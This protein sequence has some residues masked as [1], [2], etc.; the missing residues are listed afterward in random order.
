MA[1]L[2]VAQVSCVDK[3][4]E[5]EFKISI[6][7]DVIMG[8][9]IIDV[10]NAN[11]DETQISGTIVFEGEGSDLIYTSSGNKSFE[12]SEGLLDVGILSSANISKENPI[13]VLATITADGY[14]SKTIPVVFNGNE[15]INQIN[16]N[17][18]E[19]DNLPEGIQIAD[20][21]SVLVDNKITESVIFNPVNSS[22][23]TLGKFEIPEG[24]SF[25]DENGN[26][27]EGD[28]IIV[29]VA[30]FENNYFDDA[31]NIFGNNTFLPSVANVN[32]K[33]NKK[34]SKVFGKTS[35][36]DTEVTVKFGLSLNFSFYIWVRQGAKVTYVYELSKPVILYSNLGSS[37]RDF[38]RNGELFQEGDKINCYK[39]P[40]YIRNSLYNI[41]SAIIASTK[42]SEGVV[43]KIGYSKYGNVEVSHSGSYFFGY[44]KAS[45]CNIDDETNIKFVNSGVP[46]YY[47]YIIYDNYIKNANRKILTYGSFYMSSE[48][49]N[50]FLFKN[51]FTYFK[52]NDVLLE[53]YALDPKKSP[54][55]YSN[56]GI[57]VYSSEFL[58]CEVGDVIDISNN[59]CLEEEYDIDLKIDCPK[60]NLVL[61]S[62]PVY[63][64]SNK[65]NNKTYQYFA[66]VM[67][68]KINGKGPCLED[69]EE[70]QFKF[71]Y[72]G[73][74]R[75][76]PIITG[77][78]F[79]EQG[80]DFDEDELCEFIEGALKK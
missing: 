66:R 42:Y 57:N 80:F 63:F 40:E 21:S 59:F 41:N 76:S 50:D 79:K 24:T 70:Y 26:I 23:E 8:N 27:I 19:K 72:D 47:K 18:L 68:G 9:T 10:V 30:V 32:L 56:N 36:T 71:L 20:L 15:G 38:Y 62:I 64:K 58:L 53:V 22:G 6:T 2:L 73:K 55:D 37:P 46:A 16:V 3:K 4:F 1:I 14:Y 7:P 29:D 35:S 78:E 17:L 48:Y 39:A 61:N 51:Y 11:G 49:S 74:W 44:E 28:E 65:I 77:K 54:Y 69:N 5:E 45:S 33:N 31:L 75:T 13:S 12:F 43:S 67:D 60:V 25:L 52:A 34:V